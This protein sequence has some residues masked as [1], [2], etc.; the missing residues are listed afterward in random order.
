MRTFPRLVDHLILKENLLT[1]KE[2]NRFE[3]YSYGYPCNSPTPLRVY[4]GATIGHKTI[5]QFPA[6]KTEKLEVVFSEEDA[7]LWQMEGYYT[8]K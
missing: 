5:C 3:I 7:E 2:I 4:S 8:G 6:V 1:G